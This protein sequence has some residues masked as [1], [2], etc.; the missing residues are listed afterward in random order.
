MKS[1]NIE[2]LKCIHDQAE[3]TLIE[4]DEIL[5]THG[6]RLISLNLFEITFKSEQGQTIRFKFANDY[7]YGIGLLTIV[8][9]N[10]GKDSFRKAFKN[11]SPGVSRTKVFYDLFCRYFIDSI[12]K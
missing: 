2:I 4:F 7:R 1:N 12:R 6:F 9:E 5:E 11:R 10:E 8:N 3:I